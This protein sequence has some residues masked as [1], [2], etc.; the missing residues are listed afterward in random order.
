[1]QIFP[2]IDLR[3]GQVVRL[4]Q[5]D[6]DRETVYAQDPCAVARDFLHIRLVLVESGNV[7]CVHPFAH[8]FYLTLNPC[9][10]GIRYT[11]VI[12]VEIIITCAGHPAN[13]PLFNSSHATFLAWHFAAPA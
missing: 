2:A 6:Y 12:I 11:I 7:L 5:G 4:Y 13:T 10:H 3:G 9:A 1:M 8:V